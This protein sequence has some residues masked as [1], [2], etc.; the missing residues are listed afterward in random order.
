MK[1]IVSTS[2]SRIQ[3]LIFISFVLTMG[4]TSQKNK[5]EDWPEFNGG[6][7]RNH[8]SGLA[9]INKDNLDQLEKQE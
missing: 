1:S 2:G 7:D 5:N 4:C 9:Q 3:W 6:P 8:F